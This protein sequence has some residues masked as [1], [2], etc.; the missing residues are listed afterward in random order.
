VRLRPL[1]ADEFGPWSRR[2]VSGFA[3]QQVAAGVSTEPE[4][5]A[6]AEQQLAQLLPDGPTTP[7]HRIWAVHVDDG[8]AVGTL[9]LQVPRSLGQGPAYVFD[10]DIDPSHRGR[11]LGRATMLAAES[12]AREAGASAI[13]LNV[14][15]HNGA[16][17]GLYDALGYTVTR[18]TL[19]RRLERTP[20]LAAP[21]AA[22]P[23]STGVN[24]REMT[25]QE[26]AAAR[27]SLDRAAAGELPRLLPEG[28]A[29]RSQRVWV[30]TDTGGAVVG[31]AWMS[32]QHRSDGVHALVRL[33]EVRP[34]LRRR[35]YG[36]SAVQAL[37]RAAQRLRVVTLT[38]EVDDL[39]SRAMF[40]S[41]GL[42]LTA[43]TMTKAL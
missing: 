33:V 14:F 1:T 29:T 15:G 4:A 2:S 35:G 20:L 40:S 12:A 31:T 38:A 9:W 25:E 22:R 19:S 41:G 16:A 30:V 10:V 37:Q 24:L 43:Q 32:L 27:W 28:P 3:A 13:S 42:E 11:G 21:P 26:Y 7:T 5:T 8:P 23:T 18:T 36:R 6:Y 34:E 17:L 39:V